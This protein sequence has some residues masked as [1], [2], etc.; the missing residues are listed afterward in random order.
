MSTEEPL[1]DAFAD[2]QKPLAL[3]HYVFA[4][5]NLCGLCYFIIFERIKN[6]KYILI[7][8]IRIFWYIYAVFQFIF[9]TMTTFDYNYERNERTLNSIKY[10][11]TAMAIPSLLCTNISILV[12]LNQKKSKFSKLW[13]TILI[14]CIYFLPF[15]GIVF[16]GVDSSQADNREPSMYPLTVIAPL[17]LIVIIPYGFQTYAAYKYYK[18]CSE[19]IYL[20]LALCMGFGFS[21]AAIAC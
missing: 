21:V 10:L 4:W 20:A 17:T 7:N 6:G 2:G 11:A 3:A 5:T 9:C 16:V 19:N 8:R 18:Y 13:V 1:Q 14:W 12:G 15:G